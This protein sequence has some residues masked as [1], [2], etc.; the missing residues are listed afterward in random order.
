[1]CEVLLKEDFLANKECC[2]QAWMHTVQDDFFGEGVPIDLCR[3]LKQTAQYLFPGNPSR[4]HL[5]EFHCTCLVRM[6]WQ[7]GE[8]NATAMVCIQC[9]SH[10]SLSARKRERTDST[11]FFFIFFLNVNIC[12]DMLREANLECD[13]LSIM[14][15]PIAKSWNFKIYSFSGT[16][17]LCWSVQHGAFY[18]S[19]IKEFIQRWQG[20][21]EVWCFWF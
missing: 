15:I 6:T 8:E 11:V 13:F 21:V 18:F 10:L 12:I 1:M 17:T 9:L 19:P 4:W 2:S 14:K 16:Q 5:S 20:K 3:L 7:P